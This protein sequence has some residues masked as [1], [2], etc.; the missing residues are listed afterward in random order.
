MNNLLPKVCVMVA[1]YNGEKYLKEQI[2][3]ILIQEGVDL[4]VIARDDGSSDRTTEILHDYEIKGQL[5]VLMGENLGPA[6]NFYKMTQEAPMCEYYAWSDQDDIWDKDKLIEGIH[7]IQNI[8][9]PALYYSASRTVDSDGNVL[10]II[11]LDNHS[12]R[13]EQALIQSKAQGCTFVFNREMCLA[14]HRFTPNFKDLGILH[15]A[16]L[17]RVCLAIG[18]TVVHDSTPHM[19]YRIHETNVVAQMPSDS[20][21]ERLERATRI[22]ALHYCSNVAQELINGYGDLMTPSNYKL[23]RIMAE[24]RHNVMFKLWLL[25]GNQIRVDSWKDN[26]KFKCNV[27][28]NRM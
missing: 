28:F 17:H 4:T 12:L 10:S 8:L 5:K 11:G 25:F 18:G 23:A 24:Y 19:S 6:D 20:L 7:S 27:L 14:T 22:N 21:F 2:D 3:S 15:D 13:F 16:W 9:S 1:T 26:L